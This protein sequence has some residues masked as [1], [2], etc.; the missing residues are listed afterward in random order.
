MS[1]I[2]VID[3]ILLFQRFLKIAGQQNTDCSFHD[4]ILVYRVINPRR[5]RMANCH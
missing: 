5:L 4:R 3:E 2:L 1:V